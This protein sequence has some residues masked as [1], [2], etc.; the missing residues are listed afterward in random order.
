MNSTQDSHHQ[1]GGW[2]TIIYCGEWPMICDSSDDDSFFHRPSLLWVLYAE[3]KE[4]Y[5][6]TTAYMLRR[7]RESSR[8]N[9]RQMSLWI[10]RWSPRRS[11]QILPCV[12]KHK[13]RIDFDSVTIKFSSELRNKTNYG[14]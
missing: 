12:I 7:K 10:K 13:R 11:T 2:M 14:L 5:L 1:Y 6:K 4:T 8:S 9:F 3:A